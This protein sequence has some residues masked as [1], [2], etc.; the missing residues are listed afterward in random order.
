LRK[1][2]RRDYAVSAYG[3]Y[4]VGLPDFVIRRGTGS[5]IPFFVEVKVGK[6]KLS[7]E[8]RRWFNTL[9]G[10]GL[11]AHVWRCGRLPEAVGQ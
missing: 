4:V 3:T 1:L 8:Q 6:T 10:L 2:F 11:E 5:T 9:S 7:P